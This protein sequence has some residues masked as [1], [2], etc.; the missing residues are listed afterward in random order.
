MTETNIKLISLL[1]KDYFS[2]TEAAHYANVSESQFK[3][4]FKQ[5]GIR[6]FKFMCRVQFKRDE[7]ES[8]ME[9]AR[10]ASSIYS[11]ADKFL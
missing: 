10:L 1:G 6:S 5:H 8:A 11:L 4:H 9:S 7:I 2:L 3:K